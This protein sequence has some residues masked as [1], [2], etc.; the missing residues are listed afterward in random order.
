VD[1]GTTVTGW[2]EA[3]LA[4]RVAAGLRTNSISAYRTDVRYVACAGVGRIRLRDLSPEHVEEVYAY[5]VALPRAGVGSAAHA[6]AP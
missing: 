5:V 3:R 1:E 4:G 2:L 6:P